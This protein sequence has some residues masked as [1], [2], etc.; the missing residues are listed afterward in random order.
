MSATA[1]MQFMMDCKVGSAFYDYMCPEELKPGPAVDLIISFRS[2]CFHYPPSVY[3]KFVKARSQAGTKMIFDVRKARPEWR[4]ELRKEFR[5][6]AVI[7][8][9]RKW[10]RVVFERKAPQDDHE[11]G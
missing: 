5:E 4:E 11:Q 10:E 8:E 9:G 1:F 2:Y 3:M 7:H 6:L